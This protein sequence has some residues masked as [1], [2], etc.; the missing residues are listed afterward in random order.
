MMIIMKCNNIF[1]KRSNAQSW[2]SYHS[3]RPFTFK[4]KDGAT[5]GAMVSMSVFQA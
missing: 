3:D 2:K 1:I 4:I 5:R